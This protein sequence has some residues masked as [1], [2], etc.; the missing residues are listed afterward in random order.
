M[1]LNASRAFRFAQK[2]S[3][4]F[5]CL[6]K[7]NISRDKVYEKINP[8]KKGCNLFRSG[9]ARGIL[10][11]KRFFML[12]FKITFAFKRTSFFSVERIVCQA[13]RLNLW[14]LT[15]SARAFATKKLK[16]KVSLACTLFGN[17][18][19]SAITKRSLF[20]LPIIGSNRKFVKIKRFSATFGINNGICFGKKNFVEGGFES[21]LKVAGLITVAGKRDRHV[22]KL[23]CC[24]LSLKKKEFC[25]KKGTDLTFLY[26]YKGA[27]DGRCTNP[28]FMHGGPPEPVHALNK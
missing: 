27:L 23:K 1:V 6:K 13:K 9:F 24:Y 10:C 26:K 12:G 7:L 5:M 17:F 15:C 8:F 14:F 16:S 21:G 20:V 3:K 2:G 28:G 25:W 11:F 4:R 18:K 19:L 22:I